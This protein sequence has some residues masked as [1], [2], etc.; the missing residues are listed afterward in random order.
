MKPSDGENIMSDIT[1]HK[2]GYK[3]TIESVAATLFNILIWVRLNTGTHTYSMTL[4]A[5]A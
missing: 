5:Q 1:K 3:A 2:Q 4:K